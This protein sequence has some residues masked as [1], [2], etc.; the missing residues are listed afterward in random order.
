MYFHSLFFMSWTSFCII[1]YRVTLLIKKITTNYYC[2]WMYHDLLPFL[3]NGHLS[4]GQGYFL[5]NY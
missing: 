1:N 3:T 5:K 4:G 2:A